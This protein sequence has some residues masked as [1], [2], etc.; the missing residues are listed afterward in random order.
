VAMNT[1]VEDELKILAGLSADYNFAKNLTAAIQLG[2]DY[3]GFNA[4]ETIHPLS[5]LGPFQVT[6]AND[7]EFGGTHSESATRDFRFNSVTSLNYN[8]TFAEKHTI[9]ATVF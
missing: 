4:V 1:D 6:G 5:I 8:N 3:S 7:T 2:V 9:D